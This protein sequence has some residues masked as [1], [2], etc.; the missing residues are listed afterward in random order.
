MRSLREKLEA[1]SRLQE[2]LVNHPMRIFWSTCLLYLGQELWQLNWKLRMSL[3]LLLVGVVTKAMV[4]STLIFW[5][6]RWFLMPALAALPF[7]YLHP[8]YYQRAFENFAESISSP[9]ALA[10]ALSRTDPIQLRRICLFMLLVPT[11]LEMRT[12]HFLSQVS[13]DGSSVL[14]ILCIAVLSAALCYSYDR[15]KV[16]P[17]ECTKRG[18]IVMYGAALLRVAVSGDSI[19]HLPLLLAPFSLA[20]GVL[21]YSSGERD[22]EEWLSRAIRMAL[23]RTLRD[24]LAEVGES[25]QQDEMLQLAMLR[26]IVDYWTN[27]TTPDGNSG[28]TGGSERP[29][30]PAAPPTSTGERPS[31]PASSA[32]VTANTTLPGSR[33]EVQWPDL[34]LM[35]TMT[36]GQM[37]S[38]VET[39][40]QQQQQAGGSSS[41]RPASS[42]SSTSTP[43]EAHSPS[44]S[45]VQNLQAM[46]SNMDLDSH[47]KPAVEAYRRSVRDF[48]P[49]QTVSI[50]VSV[51]RR[52]PALLTL[53]VHVWFG[54]HATSG[55]LSSLLLAPIVAFELLRVQE[56]SDSCQHAT[57]LMKTASTMTTTVQTR[58][59][60]S[61][62]TGG[63]PNPAAAVADVDPM[64]LLLSHDRL[65]LHQ[66]PQLLVVWMNVCSSVGA[67]QT[68]L[69]A[70]RCVQT[71]AVAVDFCNNLVSSGFMA[72]LLLMYLTNLIM[73]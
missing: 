60:R 54:S 46:L 63:I 50:V 68:G 43:P 2:G 52:C 6:P 41:H 42:A 23:R 51:A 39:L 66:P 12:L 40:Q 48:P 9:V 17:H 59:S 55:V 3:A 47:A 72:I 38:E 32:V 35:L 14:S 67:L 28:G 31:P 21:L 33:P 10:E 56:W 20:T 71:T 19:R 57:S 22:D 64:I 16:T 5:Y 30:Q 4:L 70:V 53:I 15:G 37:E 49:S 29:P 62:N 11:V 65:S 69:T 18:L 1:Q 8:H 27:T 7:L 26:W 36:T 24:V 58:A 61:N 13:N 45:S 34:L 25:V 73:H 44:I